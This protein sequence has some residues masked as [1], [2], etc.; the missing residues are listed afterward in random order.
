MSDEVLYVKISTQELGDIEN[1][2]K[3]LEARIKEL[4][5]AARALR[6]AQRAYMA[7]R[8]DQNLG[9]MVALAAKE[10]DRVLGDA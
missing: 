8:G 6:S 2:R 5:N 9:K 7:H 10:L 4:E 3:N 1:T